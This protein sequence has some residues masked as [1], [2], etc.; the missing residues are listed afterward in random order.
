[1]KPTLLIFLIC[2]IT[3]CNPGKTKK[4]VQEE[5]QTWAKNSPMPQ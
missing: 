5:N 2:I 4:S 1:M 3:A